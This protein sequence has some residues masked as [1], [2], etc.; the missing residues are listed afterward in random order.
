MR[1]CLKSYHNLKRK[2]LKKVEQFTSKEISSI[3][4][5]SNELN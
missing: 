1:I 3:V 4:K 2:I 5:P